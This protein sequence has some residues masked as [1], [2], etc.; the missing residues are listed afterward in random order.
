MPVYT[1]LSRPLPPNVHLLTLETIN[2]TALIIRLE[3][4]YENGESE[5]LSKPVVIELDNLFL[6]FQIIS[7]TETNLSANQLW[8]DKKMWNWNTLE[9][10]EPVAQNFS[11]IR[12]MSVKL[13]PM[14]IKTFIAQVKHL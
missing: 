10:I 9:K 4:F 11:E 5:E 7:L 8:A 2:E 13:N 3:H 12:Q 6:E 14:E 1:S